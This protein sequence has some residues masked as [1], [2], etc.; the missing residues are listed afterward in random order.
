MGKMTKGL[1][2]DNDKEFEWVKDRSE[3]EFEWEC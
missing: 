3:F 2:E 1:S